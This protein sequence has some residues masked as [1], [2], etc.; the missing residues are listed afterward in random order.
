MPGGISSQF[1]TP[2]QKFGWN[3]GIQVKR[4][5][6]RQSIDHGHSCS[7]ILWMHG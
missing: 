6:P 4:L 1:S 3:Q 7:L 2:G 5:D